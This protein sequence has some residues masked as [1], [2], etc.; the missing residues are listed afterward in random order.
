LS[1][2]IQRTTYVQF[3]YVELFFKSA[4]NIRQYQWW[5]HNDNECLWTVRVISQMWVF[6]SSRVQERKD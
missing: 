5:D 2:I 1:L 4:I 3:V 6:S